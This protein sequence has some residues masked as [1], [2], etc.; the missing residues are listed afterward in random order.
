MTSIEAGV[1]GFCESLTSIIIPENV[2]SIGRNAF[3]ECT[4]L[5]RVKIEASVPP[6]IIV[7]ETSIP[8][9]ESTFAGVDK[10]IPVYVPASS[11]EAYRNSAW[12]QVFS[13]IQPM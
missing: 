8:N 11:V 4:G 9:D 2:M 7:D 1:F 10:S 6:S 5:K 13:N 12:G 3:A